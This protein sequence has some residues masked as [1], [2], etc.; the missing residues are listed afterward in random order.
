MS[1]HVGAGT[2]SGLPG[3]IARQDARTQRLRVITPTVAGATKRKVGLRG[4]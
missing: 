2:E 3:R 4:P 1:G